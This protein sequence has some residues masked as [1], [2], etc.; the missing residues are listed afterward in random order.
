MAPSNIYT[1]LV[2]LLFK[3]C[4][5]AINTSDIIEVGAIQSQYR[6]LMYGYEI[7]ASESGLFMLGNL[8]FAM[9]NGVG[10]YVVALF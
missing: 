10:Y 2:Y 5:F 1:F 8:T 9:L 3:C 6:G 4:K 7:A